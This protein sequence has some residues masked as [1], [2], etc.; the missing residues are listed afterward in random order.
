MSR[1]TSADVT[2]WLMRETPEHMELMSK[3]REKLGKTMDTD[4]TEKGTPSRDW[5]RALGRYQNTYQMLVTED[6][7]RL[8]LR[9]LMKR[10]GEEMLSDEEYESELK[11]LAVEALGTL[12][13]DKLQAELA[14]R[15]QQA[16]L[17]D[18]R[19]LDGEADDD[20]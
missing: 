13:A 5:C 19:A 10:A 20:E 12:P 11:E 14:K 3:L 8:K 1:V 7:E 9:L 16:L 4:V 6:R 17:E 18:P 15:A 2:G